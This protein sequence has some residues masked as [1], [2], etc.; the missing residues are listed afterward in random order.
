V[1]QKQKQQQT[2]RVNVTT[3]TG[4]GGTIVQPSLPYYLPEIGVQQHT[5][6]TNPVPRAFSPAF[7]PPVS[8]PPNI[9]KPPNNNA[10][11]IYA[12]E[13]SSIHSPSPLKVE[14]RPPLSQ[15]TSRPPSVNDSFVSSTISLDPFHQKEHLYSQY[16][17]L[18]DT[19]SFL[20]TMDESRR[21]QNHSPRTLGGRD[22]VD[23]QDMMR[24]LKHLF[25]NVHQ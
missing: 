4:G 14:Q 13:I 24:N 15:I 6:A 12:D 19:A 18:K 21:H 23:Q 22:W 7:V 11:L 25:Q 1:N 2:V 10:P 20:R 9:I 3:G 17:I 5:N 16:D 8:T